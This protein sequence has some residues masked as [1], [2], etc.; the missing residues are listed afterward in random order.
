MVGLDLTQTIIKQIPVPKIDQYDGEITYKDITASI[1][2][3]ILSR[4]KVLYSDDIRICGI[5]E[6][7]SLYDVTDNRKTVISDLDKIIGQMYG[8]NK[9]TLKN[10]AN[11]FDSYYSK[12]EVASFF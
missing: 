3:H 10:I 8:I 1:S 2:T 6:K 5:F 7:Y 9:K 4:L 12:E 11:S